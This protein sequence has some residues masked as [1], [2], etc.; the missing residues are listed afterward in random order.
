[1]FTSAKVLTLTYNCFVRHVDRVFISLSAI[2]LFG[3]PAINSDLFLA[4]VVTTLG[5]RLQTSALR[6]DNVSLSLEMPLS[7]ELIMGLVEGAWSKSNWSISKADN[8]YSRAG[9]FD[10]DVMFATAHFKDPGLDIIFLQ[11][12]VLDH[13]LFPWYPRIPLSGAKILAWH[14]RGSLKLFPVNSEYL[15]SCSLDVPS[16]VTKAIT[17]NQ[18][19]SKCKAIRQY[20]L[21]IPCLQV[22]RCCLLA[23]TE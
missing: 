18:H 16:F 13:I 7:K 5:R 17:T 23:F 20:L 6:R 22:S 4:D 3:F 12:V 1:M 2:A 14:Q 9:H 21:T 15:I 10:S 8:V 11:S 19:W